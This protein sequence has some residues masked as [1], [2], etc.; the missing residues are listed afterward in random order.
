[1]K[2]LFIAPLFA[3]LL[4]ASPAMAAEG[5]KEGGKIVVEGTRVVELADGGSITLDKDGKT[6]HVDAAG[7][8]VRMKDGV[9]MTGKDGAKYMHKNDAVW[10]QITEKGTLGPN[11]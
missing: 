1:M 4:I 3:A 2:S 7:K 11:R 10:K 5:A 8:R 6:Y 9:V